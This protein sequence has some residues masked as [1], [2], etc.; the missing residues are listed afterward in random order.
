MFSKNLV[1]YKSAV[2]VN[3]KRKRTAWVHE[4]ISHL[5]FLTNFK[6]H[7]IYLLTFIELVGDP[8]VIPC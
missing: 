7:R 3:S 8:K 5:M 2:I 6:L 1:Y 4:V